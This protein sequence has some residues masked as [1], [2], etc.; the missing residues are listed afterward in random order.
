MSPWLFAICFIPAGAA[1]QPPDESQFAR[2]K[3]K[4]QQDMTSI[5][6]YTCLETIE[7][8]HRDP[9]SRLFKPVDTVRLEVSS[10]NGKEL[11]AWPGGR[12]FEDKD[13]TSLVPGGAIG[14]G[15]FAGFAHTLFLSGSGAVHY[16]GEENV[17]GRGSVRYDYQLPPL[18][19]GG[20][21][22]RSSSAKATVAS[23][24]S[25]W[26]DPVSLD[27][28]RLEVRGD[29]LP[30]RL[31]LEEAVIDIDYARTHIGDSD[32]LLPKRSE[33]T[34]THFSGEASRNVIEFSQCHEYGS[35]S[36]ISFEAPSPSLPE[37]PKPRVREVQLPAGLLLPVELDTQIDSKTAAVGDA[38][39]ARVVQEVRYNG[40]LVVPR[41]AALT[42]HIRSLDR[43][44]APA[45]FAVGIEFTEVEWEGAHARFYAKLVDLDRKPAG[46]HRLQTYFDG[47]TEK[48][49]IQSE[50]PG[51]GIFFVDGAG[52]RTPPG[53]RMGW[54]TLA[55]PG[56]APNQRH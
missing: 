48:V 20:W 45:S 18:M 36:T 1:G 29:D 56:G 19:D 11:F 31:H 55:P 7:R 46:M 16:W 39:H 43:R 10:V 6:N 14:N 15:M 44:S 27:L 2:F 13:V 40:D 52:F 38:L 37:A 4:I 3:E 12:R 26:F 54:R 5:P 8:T 25:F 35:E 42:G 53:F 21:E 28:I 47:R 34:M 24:G 17:A 23:K 49:L 33:L 41:G 51:V 22:I 50:I 9:H 32:A 30:I